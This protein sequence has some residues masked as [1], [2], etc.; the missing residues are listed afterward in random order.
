M[1]PKLPTPTVS[2]AISRCRGHRGQIV[3]AFYW[4]PVAVVIL[5][6]SL[7]L[8]LSPFVVAAAAAAAAADRCAAAVAC[9]VSCTAAAAAVWCGTIIVDGCGKANRGTILKKSILRKSKKV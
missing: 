8:L 3:G 5:P 1:T 2:L 6:P 9:V 7:P 4:W